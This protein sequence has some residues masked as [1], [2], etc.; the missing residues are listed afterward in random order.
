MQAGVISAFESTISGFFGSALY[1]VA[2]YMSRTEHLYM[3]SHFT[4]SQ[5]T[6]DRLPQAY[7]TIIQAVAVEAATLGVAKGREYDEALLERMQAEH[8]FEANPVDTAPFVRIV[9]PLHDELAAEV[10]GSDILAMI[11]ALD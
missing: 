1:E 7:R 5:M 6:Y 8:G 3:L 10:N 9:A 11:R 2:A 4:M